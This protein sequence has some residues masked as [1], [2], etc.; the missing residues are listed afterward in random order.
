MKKTLIF[1][2]LLMALL[3][4]AISACSNTATPVSTDSPA[5]PTEDPTQALIE[6]RC[7]GCHNTSIIYNANYDESGWSDV[8]DHMI[9]KGAVLSEDEKAQIIEWL[10]A[11]P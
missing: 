6:E 11:Q 1:S 8:I 10:I 3:V 4:V 9:E 2:I 5:T 7:S